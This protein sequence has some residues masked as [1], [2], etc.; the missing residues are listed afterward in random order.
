MFCIKLYWNA[1]YSIDNIGSNNLP[2]ELLVKYQ[3]ANY[4]LQIYIE[5]ETE[6]LIIVQ[7]L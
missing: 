2:Q 5:V 7:C 4:L 3:L 1:C 6:E